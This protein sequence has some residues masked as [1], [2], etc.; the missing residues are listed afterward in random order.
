MRGQAN[1]PAMY[2]VII[3]AAGESVTGLNLSDGMTASV[4]IFIERRPNV[5]YL[6]V[7]AVNGEDQP[8]VEL[9]ADGAVTSASVTLG[10]KTHTRVEIKEGLKEGDT[11]RVD[12]SIGRVLPTN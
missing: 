5:L 1:G 6:P 11:V 4:E 3:L 9:V 12:L 2:E 8:S 10:L 7:A